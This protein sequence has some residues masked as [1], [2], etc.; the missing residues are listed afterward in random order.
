MGEPTLLAAVRAN[1][2][3]RVLGCRK[4]PF[5]YALARERWVMETAEKRKYKRGDFGVNVGAK[6]P[7]A[8]FNEIEDLAKALGQTRAG[9]VRL[10]LRRGL[11]EYRRNETLT[12]QPTMPSG[13]P[14]AGS[15]SSDDR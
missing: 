5:T 7:P 12:A 4:T 8:T 10:L 13:V 2:L 15:D 3:R 1:E 9:V 11:A 14:R 6:V